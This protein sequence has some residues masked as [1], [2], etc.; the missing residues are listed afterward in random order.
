MTVHV[1]EHVGKKNTAVGMKTGAIM[2]KISVEVP[3]KNKNRT[4][5]HSTTLGPRCLSQQHTTQSL[6]HHVYCCYVHSSQDRESV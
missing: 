2:V 6:A 4:Y 5:D 1:G 3:Q